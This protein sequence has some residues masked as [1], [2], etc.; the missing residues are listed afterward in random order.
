MGILSL[1]GLEA[2][3]KE[4][5]AKVDLEFLVIVEARRLKQRGPQFAERIYG[6]G[7]NRTSHT[8]VSLTP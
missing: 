3:L 7:S 4:L 1:N 6:F 8:L 5:L 2:N